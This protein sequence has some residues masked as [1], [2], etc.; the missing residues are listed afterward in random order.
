MRTIARSVS[1]SV[2]MT[3]AAKLRP[4]ARVTEMSSAPAITWLLVS[5]KPASASTIT[6]EPRLCET[7]SRGTS[8]MLKK[9]RK[10]GSSSSG[11][12]TRTRVWV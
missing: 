3:S 1:G 10:K 4:S 2:P 11:L 8:G 5:T 7:R 9:R 6:P 12:R